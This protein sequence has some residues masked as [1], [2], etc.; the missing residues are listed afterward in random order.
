MEI[1]MVNVDELSPLSLLATGDVF[2]SVKDAM[3]NPA[4]KNNILNSLSD[5]VEKGSRNKYVSS[6]KNAGS[7]MAKAIL[8][9][10]KV[11]VEP[12]YEDDFLQMAD[13]FKE[14]DA[15]KLPFPKLTIISGENID[16]DIENASVYTRTVA[17]RALIQ[18]GSINMLYCY[19][20]TQHD[21]GIDVDILL[22]KQGDSKG[23]ML[24]ISTA[25]I[26]HDGTQLQ[27]LVEND[28]FRTS[29]QSAIAAIYMMTMGKNNFYM[30]VPTAEEAA[31]NRKRIN[32]GKKP[33]IEFK[34]AV[35]EGKKSV[36]SSTPHGT[37]ASPRLHW[38][39]GHW[40]R[41]PKSGKQIWIE[42]MEVGDEE[43]GRIIKTY[44]IGKYSL[45][46]NDS[47]RTNRI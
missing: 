31:T 27:F 38:R 21:H 7:E 8:E 45:L 39:R 1:V 32:K 35:I 13:A 11:I 30:S 46:E 28:K 15:I 14:V 43:N 37:H 6:K 18:D 2:S 40:R 20:L 4:V 9:Y 23:S 26:M 36:M 19:F 24:Y 44:A 29:L 10:P 42:P 3:Q 17:K 33:L 47:G 5:F 25:V 34:M 22:T 12:H 41:T 16:I